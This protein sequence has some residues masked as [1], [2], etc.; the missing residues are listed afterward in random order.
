LAN[1]PGASYDA[2]VFRS[3]TDQAL[4][5]FTNKAAGGPLGRTDPS[6]LSPT[7]E[8]SLRSPCISWFIIDTL[9]GCHDRRRELRE[10]MLTTLTRLDT[11]LSAQ[12]HF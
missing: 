10:G 11:L 3:L 7:A 1:D 6:S 5:L 9:Y 2:G 4:D 8:V 12:R